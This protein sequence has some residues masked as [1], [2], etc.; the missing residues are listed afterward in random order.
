LDPCYAG[1]F[2]ILERIGTVAYNLLLSDR[3]CIHDI[4]HVGLLKPHRG[5]SPAAP[6][7]LP[8]LLDE[9]ILPEPKTALQ[10]QLR[11]GVWYIRIK[12]RGLT[13][14]DATWEKLDEFHGHYPDF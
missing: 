7:A 9:C 3:A 5:E 2:Q 6:T 12:W 10:A 14:E 13:K 1:P 11:R 8:P 4:F